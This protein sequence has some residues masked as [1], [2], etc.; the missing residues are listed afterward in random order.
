M[1]RV[2]SMYGRIKVANFFIKAGRFIQDAAVIVMRPD[3]LLEFSR[4]HYLKPETIEDWTGD[5][6]VHSGLSY[7]EQPLLHAD[8][9]RG[10]KLLLL[11][12]GGGREAIAL[13]KMGFEVTGVDFVPQM[14]EAAEAHA[15]KSGIKL[16]TA[17]QE[18]S[19]LEMP[20]ETFSVAW[21]S[22]AMYS[23]VPTRKKRVDML[24]RILKTLKPG[25]YFLFEFL[26]RPGMNSSAKAYKL[27]KILA[28]LSFGYREYEKGDMLRFNQ[29]FFHGFA[30]V[31]EL[32]AELAEAGFEL[33]DVQA[34]DEYEFA[35]AVARKPS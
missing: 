16:A 33:I 11:G 27:K 4:R 22:A 18:I 1:F 14:V 26:W 9:P 24:K 31:T 25:G 21:L 35:G 34:K 32:R 19:R 30:T 15:R 7:L 6:R 12:L 10:G 2:G 23:C 13:A 28:G 17:I 5:R 8:I 3:D 29:E 20:E